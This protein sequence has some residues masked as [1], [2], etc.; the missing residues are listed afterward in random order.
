MHNEAVHDH[1]SDISELLLIEDDA[2]SRKRKL[3]VAVT[4]NVAKKIKEVH[5]C[6]ICKKDFSQR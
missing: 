5:R 3:A 1:N 2:I 6:L 4:E